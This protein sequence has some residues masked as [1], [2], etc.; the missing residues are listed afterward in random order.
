MRATALNP[1]A[2]ISCFHG[3]ILRSPRAKGRAARICRSGSARRAFCA[4]AALARASIRVARRDHRVIVAD[5][6]LFDR[7]GRLVATLRGARYHAARPRA[8]ARLSDLGL[9][10]QWIPAPAELAARRAPLAARREKGACSK[11]GAASDLYGAALLLEG[12]A[13][14][15]AFQFGRE[16]ARDE[17]SIW[18]PLAD[19]LGCRSAGAPSRRRSRR[20]RHSGL[21]QRSDAACV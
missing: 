14:A 3:L 9:V 15:A 13:T 2:S 17:L 20:P 4:G 11:P 7:D 1:R 19:G 18:R 6:D 21:I 16:L 8:G 5:F 12:W 10:A